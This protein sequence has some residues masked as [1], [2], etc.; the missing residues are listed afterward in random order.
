MLLD[1]GESPGQETDTNDA[2]AHGTNSSSQH[3]LGKSVFPPN[4]TSVVYVGLCL[5]GIDT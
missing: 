5:C 4:R 3:S 1:T 2:K